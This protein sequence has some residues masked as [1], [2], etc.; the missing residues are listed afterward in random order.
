MT[1]GTPV[2]LP[3]RV[4]FH[5]GRQLGFLFRSQ[6]Q[7]VFRYGA[8]ASRVVGNKPCGTVFETVMATIANTTLK[9]GSGGE[10][11]CV[12]ELLLLW[13]IATC[14]NKDGGLE[15]GRIRVTD[16]RVQ[17]IDI[18]VEA[19]GCG[20]SLRVQGQ[21][22][23][24]HETATARGIVSCE[25]V[26]QSALRVVFVSCEF[27]CRQ[28]HVDRRNLVAKRE[29]VVL[30]DYQSIRVRNH[31]HGSEVIGVDVVN[32]PA[33]TSSPNEA[34]FRGTT[35]SSEVTW[36]I[37]SELR[38]PRHAVR[39][40]A[41]VPTPSTSCSVGRCR[42]DLGALVGGIPGSVDGGDFVVKRRSVGQTEV[43]VR[44][45]RDRMSVYLG[46]HAPGAC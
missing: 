34:R 36:N 12:A 30:R 45:R 46:E 42:G 32:L 7:L 23:T 11:C 4:V 41:P 24:T 35:S 14:D 8:P 18:K 19:L 44:L 38:N 13:A 40:T 15:S 26:L 20:Q 1:E 21:W 3:I 29:V 39:F 25:H 28:A 2:D 27:L 9:P 17:H 6:I 33:W 43:G 22:I 31:P 10:Q 16:R 37:E 5:E